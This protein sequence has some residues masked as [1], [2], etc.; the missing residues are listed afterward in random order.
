MRSGDRLDADRA[1]LALDPEFAG[2][3]I[4]DSLDHLGMIEAAVLALEAAPQDAA[5]INEVF[6][7]FHTVKG[8][9]GALNVTSVQELAH[10]VENLL[11][12]A[13]S[14]KHRLARDRVR[15]HPESPSIC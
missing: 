4:T 11:D 3:F 2:I 14:G 6:R 10:R 12:L 7:P 9:A 5:L 8:N 15:H 1:T 13:R